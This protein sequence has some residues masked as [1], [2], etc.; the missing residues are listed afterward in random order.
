MA[1]L[2]VGSFILSSPIWIAGIVCLALWLAKK[3]KGKNVLG[4]M[5]A[6]IACFSVTAAFVAILAIG[7]AVLGVDGNADTQ[8]QQVSTQQQD[9]E[10]QKMEAEQQREEQRQREEAEKQQ[11]KENLQ[12]TLDEASTYTASE[13][14]PE[15]FQKLTDAIAAASGTLADNQST[16]RELNSARESVNT[17]INTLEKPKVY[18]S[19]P[20]IDVARNPDSYSGQYL[21]FTGRVVQVIE[22]DSLNSIR[23]ATDGSYDDIVLVSYSPSIMGGT[24]VL[25]DDTITVNG[26]CTGL[27]TYTSTMGAQI[28]IPGMTADQITIN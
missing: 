24:R 14:T 12:L 22:S 13:Y 9:D 21:T 1:L 6:W 18:Q 25:E 23:L 26:M 28:S 20:Y 19:L 10:A 16:T 11:A 8:Q 7:G 3:K 27:V 4:L 15:S 2:I 5:I 17:A